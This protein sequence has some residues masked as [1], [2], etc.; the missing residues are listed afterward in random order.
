MTGVPGWARN[1]DP[2][3][4]A[5]YYGPVPEDNVG[6]AGDA[7]MAALKRQLMDIGTALEDINRR[8]DGIEKK[9]G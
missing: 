9:K 8:L 3:A 6:P 1:R 2:E 4:E 7:E 5:A